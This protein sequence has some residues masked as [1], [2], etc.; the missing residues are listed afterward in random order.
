MREGAPIFG[1][2]K[3]GNMPASKAQQ[4]ATAKYE[5]KVYDKTLLRL[6]KGK[7]N[8]IRT[9]ADAA[10]ESVNAYINKAVDERIER[11]SGVKPAEGE[12]T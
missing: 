9:A 1:A 11:E 7:L 10:G 6:P 12:N 2:P 5:A 8:E 3:G 4:K